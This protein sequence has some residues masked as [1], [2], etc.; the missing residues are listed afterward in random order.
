MDLWTDIWYVGHATRGRASQT[1]LCMRYDSPLSLLIMS[2]ELPAGWHKVLSVRVCL[3]VC[4][5]VSASICTHICKLWICVY[6][7]PISN[8]G[9]VPAGHL[10]RAMCV[11]ALRLWHCVNF[12]LEIT[13]LLIAPQRLWSIIVINKDRP[14]CQEAPTSLEVWWQWQRRFLIKDGILPP[15]LP[16][17]LSRPLILLCNY[18][19]PLLGGSRPSEQQRC[20]TQKRNSAFKFQR[21]STI[22]VCTFIS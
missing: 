22:T 14:V 9:L 12:Q 1:R 15:A 5:S 7:S 2:V 4:L 11:C 3:S 17:K 8:V 20:E 16:Q 21:W 18:H 10:W 13:L 6:Q 19:F